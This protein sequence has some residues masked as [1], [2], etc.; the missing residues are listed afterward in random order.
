MWNARLDEAQAVTKI[1]GRNIKNLRYAD[2]TTL[3]AESEEQ[4][5]NLL[6]KWKRRVK[7]L[8]KVQHSRNEDHVIRSHHFMANRWG[9]VETVADFTFWG[10]TITA[11]G[12][13]SME[14]KD[15]CF[16]KKSYDQPR[17]HFKKQRHYFANKGLPCQSYGFSSIHAWMCE[18]DYKKSWAPKD[19]CFWIVVLE[20][21]L[22]SPLDC[23]E[24][25][26][27]HP[28]GNQSWLFIGRTNAE[29][30]NPIRWPPYEKNW[31]IGKDL[32]AGKD[33]RQ[34]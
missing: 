2:D 12:D 1:T 9:T 33:W 28:K 13:C 15:P 21:T 4:L 19:W 22:E 10:S 34:D 32:D 3:M 30:E 24:I 23:K 6:T 31:P 16:F 29:A 14:L 26:P 11:E 20:K 7:N 27:D 18:L 17:Q 5:K 25:Q 8:L